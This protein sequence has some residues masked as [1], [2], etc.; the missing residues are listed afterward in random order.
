MDW[1]A[2]RTT[3]REDDIAYCLIGLFDVNMPLLYGEDGIKAFAR[4]QEE[5][6]K[7]GLDQSFLAW[8]LP[9]DRL[10]SVQTDLEFFA[11]H[12]KCL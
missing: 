4:L 5:I 12:P 6:T 2:N 7:R 10:L 11:D 3:T 8:L 1:A 9:T